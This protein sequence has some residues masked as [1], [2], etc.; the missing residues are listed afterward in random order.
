MM[1]IV[2]PERHPPTSGQ[3][4]HNPQWHTAAGTA[5]PTTADTGNTVPQRANPT[6]T[7]FAHPRRCRLRL[8]YTSLRPDARGAEY[9][10]YHIQLEWPEP[11]DDEEEGALPLVPIPVGVGSS[12]RASG[13][14]SPLSSPGGRASIGEGRGGE[15]AH[16]IAHRFSDFVALDAAIREYRPEVAAGLPP[17]PTSMTLNKLS[18]NVVHQRVGALQAYLDYVA[19]TPSLAQLEHVRKFLQPQPEA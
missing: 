16:E 13:T 17:L 6:Q 8:L 3:H 19:T 5:A 7:A 2:Y 10:L 1:I 12:L 14:L 4:G 18:S 11:E 9:T 15:V